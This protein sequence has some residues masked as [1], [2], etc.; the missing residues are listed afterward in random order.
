MTEIILNSSLNESFELLHFDTT[1][2]QE[3]EG[4][5][6]FSLAKGFRLWGQYRRFSKKLRQESP[7]LVLIPLSQ[8]PGG[9]IKDLRFVRIAHKAGIRTVAHL[10]GGELD[11]TLK[12]SSGALRS[13]AEKGLRLLDGAMVLGDGLRRIF[14]PYLP[15]ERLF[16]VPN[17]LDIPAPEKEAP[18]APPFRILFLSNPIRR[19][20]IED[21]LEALRVL[22]DQG[23]MVHF[24]VAGEWFEKELEKELKERVEQEQLPVSFHPPLGP[25]QKR[26]LLENAHLFLLPPREPEGLPVAL[27][28]AL[29]HKLPIISTEQG[30]I[31]EVVTDGWNGFFVLPRDPVSIA[32]R[33]AELIVD[34]RKR[35]QFGERSRERYEVGFTE[36][37]L[38]ENSYHCF[39]T[40]LEQPLRG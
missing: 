23:Y 37:R 19:K 33:T 13:H 10:H 14:R 27:I 11:R 32:D 39:K 3:L 5:G 20:G 30:A 26:S 4:I 38:S 12:R 15:D 29:A 7:E 36:K 34:P 6:R 16:T 24:D 18:E 8:T 9:L 2:N 17:G 35:E 28:E 21:A 31:P 25:S 1:L 40:L 22:W